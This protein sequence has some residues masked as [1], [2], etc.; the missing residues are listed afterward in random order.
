MPRS[1]RVVVAGEKGEERL[2]WEEVKGLDGVA[3]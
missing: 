2:A 1:A 3:I